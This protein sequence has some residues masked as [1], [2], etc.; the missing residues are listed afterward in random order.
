MLPRGPA[1]WTLTHFPPALQP[2]RGRRCQEGWAQ[3][4]LA[5]QPQVSCLMLMCAC[6][7]REGWV[8][9]LQ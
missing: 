5:G 4:A 6:V 3:V 8:G 7:R 1:R 2:W 9:V